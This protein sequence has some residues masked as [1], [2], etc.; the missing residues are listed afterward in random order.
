VSADY[1]FRVTGRL[2]PGLLK[3][4]AP[5]AST[6]S[7]TGTVLTAR[8]PD[9]ATLHGFIARIAG[10]GLE[11]VELQR[12][13]PSVHH[14]QIPSPTWPDEWFRPRKGMLVD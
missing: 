12:L 7:A 4:L 5:L 14:E 2:T 1:S 6:E 10:L 3:A 13:P 8:V 11:L 9:Q